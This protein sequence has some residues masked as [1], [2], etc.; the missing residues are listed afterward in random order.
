MAVAMAPPVATSVARGEGIEAYITDQWRAGTTE[1]ILP[2]IESGREGGGA[3][4]ERGEIPERGPGW[5][6]EGVPSLLLQGLGG[7]PASW[8]GGAGTMVVLAI[9]LPPAM[10]VHPSV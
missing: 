6:W 4:P 1:E 10:E 3:I 8:G 5:L 9:C 2:G 7:T